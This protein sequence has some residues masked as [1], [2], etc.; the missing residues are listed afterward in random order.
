VE[1]ASSHTLFKQTYSTDSNKTWQLF[2]SV[3]IQRCPV[4]TQNK[5]LIESEF[6][7]VL[8]QIE[9]ERSLKSDHELR[10]EE[11]VYLVQKLK[12][13]DD[14]EDLD[15]VGLQTAQ[16]F[17]DT[18]TEE[19]NKFKKADRVTE[20]DKKGDKKS[21][22]RCLDKIL[23]LVVKQT[24]GKVQPWVF[25]MGL[26]Q[27]GETLRQTCDRVVESTVGPQ[28]ITQPLGNAPVGLY[29]YTLP[30]SSSSERETNVGA[31]VF[32][33]KSF[34]RG[35]TVTTGGNGQVLDYQWLTRDELK[36]VLQQEYYHSISKFLIDEDLEVRAFEEL[37]GRVPRHDLWENTR[38]DK[39]GERQT[40]KV[41]AGKQ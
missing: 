10:H 14:E 41:R 23:Y 8:A 30:R 40:A 2:S 37:K 22:Q 28:L 26:R 9:Y 33:F 36:Q 5:T 6:T 35:G 16:D 21:T 3:C 19:L 7:K 15:S 31:K 13:G 39:Q 17:E 1:A 32:F 25:P 18:G 4:I 29:K 20:A 38:Q 11:D 27:D 12:E 24:L 34:Y